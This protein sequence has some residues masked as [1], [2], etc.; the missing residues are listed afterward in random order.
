[1]MGRAASRPSVGTEVDASNRDCCTTSSSV[2]VGRC[3]R[4]L[5]PGCRLHA[6]GH[7]SKSIAAPMTVLW[8]LLSP[9]ELAAQDWRAQAQQ[10]LDALGSVTDLINQDTMEATVTPFETDAPPE[11]E[12]APHQIEDEVFNARVSDTVAA[13]GLGAQVD[14]ALTRPDVDLGDNPLALAD[15]AVGASEA[16]AGGLF[17]PGGEA[18]DASLTVTP[19]DEVL[20]CTSVAS[21]QYQTCRETRS[22]ETDRDDLWA[23][24]TEDLDY[25][26]RCSQAVSWTCTGE[27]GALCTQAAVS[28][29]ASAVWRAGATGFDVAGT[30][31]TDTSCTLQ[32]D[33]FTVT[34][35][36]AV[37]LRSL[38][39]DQVS[40]NGAAQ[41]RVNGVNVWTYGTSA[42]GDLN[43][44][45][46]DCGKDCSRTAAYA[47]SDWIEDCSGTGRNANPGVDLRDVVPSPARGPSSIVNHDVV[48][49]AGP[50]ATWIIEVIR[51][52]RR[53]NRVGLG[54][55][56]AG[57][58]CSA[59]SAETGGACP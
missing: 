23:C 33:S 7:R 31:S 9:C 36:S 1:M 22:I 25:K 21:A 6:N 45:N 12:I 48:L 30:L 16:V 4:E 59:I 35:S 2:M 47:G 50:D 51:I 3:G 11:A 42:T 44:R 5:A 8:L 24:S 56:V 58:C 40:F 13:R 32:S 15:A 20:Y 55:A 14:S 49:S 34:A 43:V 52:N 27:T 18:C 37:D 26:K 28:L 57:S 17:V 54:V 41:I 39:V 46:R 53:E 10:S 29:P 38:I 19:R